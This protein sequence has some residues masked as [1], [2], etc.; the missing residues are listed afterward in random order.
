MTVE[1]IDTVVV[2]GGQAGLSV[3]YH[4]KKRGIQFVI[5]DASSRI[6][7]AWRNRWDSL[8]VFTPAR[9]SS[10]D[11]MPFPADPHSF[12]SKDAMGDYLEMYAR[13]FQLPVR[14][15]VRVERLS[16][17]GDRFL[18]VAGNQQIEAD[19]VVVAMANYQRPRIPAFAS[20]LH[21]RIVQIHSIDYRNPSQ[22][23]PGRV[24]IV[25][26]GNSGAEIALDVVRGHETWLSGRDT[27]HVPF[28]I[29]GLLARLLMIRL[30]LRVVFH[31]I[32]TVRTPMGRK[33]RARARHVG[34]TL[35]RTK[36]RDLVA[37]GI[38]RVPRV[39]RVENGLPVLEDGRVVDVANVVWCTGFHPGFSW[40]DLP[41]F[42][43]DGE[44]QHD[45]GEVANE[46]GLFFVG[47]HFLHAMSSVMIHG[48]GRDAARIADR[49]SATRREADEARRPDPDA[50]AAARV[51]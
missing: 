36:P 35:V 39:A 42:G 5:L 1:R 38:K 44:P 13:R 18:V 9:F 16:R 37:A 29:D 45:S 41:V 25:G 17:L 34:G 28:R 20:E 31:R 27:G 12:P 23:Q 4:L 15:G 50:G 3:G 11:G 26:A 32:L 14:C 46:P 7:D 30:V 22:L 43:P 2:G 47:L 33:A 40:I 49:I 8:R 6:G 24:L 51:A 48:V 19:N 10:L 21:S